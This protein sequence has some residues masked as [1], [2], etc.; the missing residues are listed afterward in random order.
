MWPVD[1]LHQY[2][3]R[4]ESWVHTHPRVA[5][6][7]CT[8]YNFFNLK[9]S[10]DGW[11]C[12]Y[13]KH[14]HEDWSRNNFRNVVHSLSNVPQTTDVKH[15]NAGT[16]KL[17]AAV[18]IHHST[19]CLATSYHLLVSL[20]SQQSR[21]DKWGLLQGGASGQPSKYVSRDGNL[22][23]GEWTSLLCSLRTATKKLQG[24]VSIYRATGSLET[25]Q[26][27]LMTSGIGSNTRYV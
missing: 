8:D 23:C 27:R 10:G 26:S 6:C 20:T 18:G 3:Q 24:G 1:S 22:V 11:Y 12:R 17:S 15:Y 5:G 7:H 25:R 21:T 2:S 9:I 16:R 19:G 4:F 13:N 14:S